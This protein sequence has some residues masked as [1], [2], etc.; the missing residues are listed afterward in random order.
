VSGLQFL[1]IELDESK[2]ATAV[3]IESIITHDDSRVKVIV[4]PANEEL[5]IALDTMELVG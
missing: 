4:V 3:G 1:G 2:N 5:V